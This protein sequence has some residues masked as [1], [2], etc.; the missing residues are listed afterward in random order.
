MASVPLQILQTKG[1]LF[2]YNVLKTILILTATTVLAKLV[3]D[4][5]LN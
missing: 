5:K 4:L 1:K 2:F 3:E